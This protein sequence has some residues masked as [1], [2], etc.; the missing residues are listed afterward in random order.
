MVERE[1][2]VTSCPDCGCRTRGGVCSNCHEELYVLTFQA[3]DLTE[4]VSDEFAGKARRQ[5]EE[6]KRRSEEA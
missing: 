5:S 4:P 1:D 3:D 6:L 2:S